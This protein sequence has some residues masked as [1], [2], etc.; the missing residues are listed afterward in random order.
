MTG[1]ECFFV[2]CGVFALVLAFGAVVCVCVDA[3]LKHK[4]DLS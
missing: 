1:T 3:A 2:V 4:K